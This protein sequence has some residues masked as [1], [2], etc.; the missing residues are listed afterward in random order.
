MKHWFPVPLALN[1]TNP[2]QQTSP[3]AKVRGG[4]PDG[5]PDDVAWIVV[6]NAGAPSNSNTFG[7][8][9]QHGGQ[10]GAIPA[11]AGMA[12]TMQLVAKRSYPKVGTIVLETAPRPL[13]SRNPVA[14]V[15]LSWFDVSLKLQLLYEGKKTLTNGQHDQRSLSKR[16]MVVGCSG[17]HKI[18]SNHKAFLKGQQHTK[19]LWFLTYNLPQPH[20][21]IGSMSGVPLHALSCAACTILHHTTTA[22]PRAASAT[23][24]VGV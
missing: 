14:R 15:F 2:F 5:G 10:G 12:G 22:L 4:T 16:G 21:V 3:D 7:T 20:G 17:S 9:H 1:P 8:V 6:G 13:N 18:C 24:D 23:L 11:L 19:Y